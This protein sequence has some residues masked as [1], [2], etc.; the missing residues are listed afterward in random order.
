MFDLLIDYMMVILYRNI[1]LTLS[2]ISQKICTH[3]YVKNI[4]GILNTIAS[5]EYYDYIMK[6]IMLRNKDYLEKLMIVI[7]FIL[8]PD[9]YVCKSSNE[10]LKLLNCNFDGAPENENNTSTNP[11]FFHYHLKYFDHDLHESLDGL[12]NES[13]HKEIKEYHQN[14]KKEENTKGGLNLGLFFLKQQWKRVTLKYFSRKKILL[15][16]LLPFHC[17]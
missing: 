10:L 15:I 11:S 16:I 5:S 12:L 3:N 13:I 8:N 4:L 6:N 2:L 1:D 9:P 14:E 17:K 7:N